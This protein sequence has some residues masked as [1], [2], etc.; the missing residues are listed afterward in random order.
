MQAH[1]ILLQMVK[2]KIK[3]IPQLNK[4]STIVKSAQL[5]LNQNKSLNYMQLIQ[6]HTCGKSIY[7]QMTYLNIP[8][9]YKI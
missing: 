6:R 8:I 1:E 7:E 5:R 4:D 9:Q 3:Q 2:L